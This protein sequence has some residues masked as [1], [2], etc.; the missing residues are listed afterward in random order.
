MPPPRGL[1]RWGFRIVV[2]EAVIPRF[3]QVGLSAEAVDGFRNCDLNTVR[4]AAVVGMNTVKDFLEL[5]TELVDPKTELN[6]HGERFRALV[7]EVLHGRECAAKYG[8]RL[9]EMVRKTAECRVLVARE[10]DLVRGAILLSVRKL[11]C[12]LM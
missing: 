9:G 7:A 12:S 6:V 10:V 3:P 2:G 11:L 5:V 8:E 1:L 4:A